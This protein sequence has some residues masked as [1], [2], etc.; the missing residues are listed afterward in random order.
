M[1]VALTAALAMG[2]GDDDGPTPV[3]AGPGTD[4]GTPPGTDGGPACGSLTVCGTECVDTRFDPANCGGC[5][6]ACGAG[7]LCNMGTC[8]SS[9]GVGTEDCGGMCVD[10]SVDPSNCGGC[11]VECAT[12]EVCSSGSCELECPGGLT[13]CSGGCVDTDSDV[14]N[15][16]GCGTA[17][18]AG[19]ACFSGVCG[20]RPTVDDDSDTISN[21]DEQSDIPRD[22]DGDGTPD[23]EDTDSDD[24][25]I[26]D[27]DEAGDDNVATPPVDSDG[28]GT[29]D[30]QDTDSDNDGVSDADEVAGGTDPTDPDTDGDGESDG[31]EITGGS[32]PLDPDDSVGGGGGFTFDLPADGMDRTDTLQFEPRIQRA[33]VLFL[34]DTTGSMGGEIDNLQASLASVVTDVRAVIA[35]TA[36]GVARFDDFPT[37][38]YGSASC[39]GERDLPFELEQRITTDMGAITSGVD[40]LDMPLHCGNDGPESQIEGLFQA[41]TGNGFRAPGG[42]S[43]ASAFDPDAGFDA[44]LGHGRIGGAGFRADRLPVIVI[45]TDNTFHR[46]WDDTTVTADRLTWCG[47][48]MGDTCNP[49]SMGDFGSAADQT[50]ATVA[51]TLMALNGIGAK[52]IGVASEGSGGSDQRTEL[53]AFSIATGSYKEPVGGVCDTGLMGADRAPV[54]VD[55]DGPG[56]EPTQELCPLVYSINGTGSGLGDSITSA[57]TDLT[58]FVSFSTLHTEARDDES[59]PGLDESEFFLRGIPVRADPATCPTLPTVADR[60][61]SGGG[62]G[63]DGEFDS[64][65]GVEPGCLVTFQIVAQNDGL[66]DATCEDQLFD[67]RVIVVGDDVV[68]ADSRVVVV[69]VPGD[70]TLCGS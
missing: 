64:F 22:T 19:Q 51:E 4:T 40:A 13:E 37:A 7:E 67:L 24:D 48:A 28:D 52:V 61:T 14:N 46:R 26:S 3:D 33:D 43:W 29:P 2:C 65:V 21:F 5:D 32:D 12:G 60:L 16:G 31:V 68:E 6:V 49:Y 11:G 18:E 42:A 47:D 9:C 45:A 34:V 39:N 58:S 20:M 15:C 54:M 27:A 66:V 50:P 53:E 59:T 69:R 23:F 70:R 56:P 62:L 57:I 25:G 30:F 63:S 35:D 17:C 8:A 41:A 36:F 44:A 38:G 10:T 55:P 1:G